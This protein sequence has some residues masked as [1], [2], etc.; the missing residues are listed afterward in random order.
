MTSRELERAPIAA[1][2]RGD[3]RLANDAS[4][5]YLDNRDRV[6]ITMRIDTDHL[7]PT[8]LQASEPTSSD[9]L[10]I[11]TGAGLGIGT[12]RGRTMMSHTLGWTGF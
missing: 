6:H 9:T 3:R 10:G 7:S 2:V 11:T 1:R 12:A 8:D 5:S 4:C